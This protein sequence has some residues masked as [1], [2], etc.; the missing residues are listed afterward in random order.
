MTIAFCNLD[1]GSAQKKFSETYSFALIF[2]A[3][4]SSRR[5]RL[6]P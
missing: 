2:S 1:Q 5:E 4:V 3:K 6:S